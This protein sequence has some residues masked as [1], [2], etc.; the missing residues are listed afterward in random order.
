[1]TQD[2]KL[3]LIIE[4]ISSMDKRFDCVDERLDSM[5]KRF[6]SMDERLDSMDKRFCSM[7]EMFNSMHEHLSSLD[8]SVKTLQSDVSNIN[9]Q[10][11]NEIIP[12]IKRVAE[13]HLDLDRKFQATM[14]TNSEYEILTLRVNHLETVVNRLEKKIS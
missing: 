7:D 1:M 5:D 12:D 8:E 11:E 13:G 9:L 4:K 6:D 10:I 2:E 3:N 14:H